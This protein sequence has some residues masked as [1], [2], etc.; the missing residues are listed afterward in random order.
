M[1]FC[2]ERREGISSSHSPVRAFV[3]G[4]REGTGK[5]F[6]FF[7]LNVCICGGMKYLLSQ[8][9]LEPFLKALTGADE[10]HA[11]PFPNVCRC[12]EW[13]GWIGATA[14]TCI[15]PGLCVVHFHYRWR[16]PQNLQLVWTPSA[17]PELGKRLLWFAAAAAISIEKNL[18]W[19][20]RWGDLLTS[21]GY[22]W[23]A[24]GWLAITAH[25]KM[26]NVWFQWQGR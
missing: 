5:A 22:F 25:S 19:I 12:R 9:L 16:P 13:R 17:W 6:L 4:R 1:P 7:F 14:E 8:A 24:R 20:E 2:W 15:W 23:C 21:L 3:T 18:S 11:Q 26:R 10:K